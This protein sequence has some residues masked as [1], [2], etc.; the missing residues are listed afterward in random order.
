MGEWTPPTLLGRFRS[1]LAG[2]LFLLAGR[3]DR[4]YDVWLDEAEPRRRR[5]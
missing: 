1:W 4:T 3:I 5:A 2:T